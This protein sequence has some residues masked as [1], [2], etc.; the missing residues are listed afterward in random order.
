MDKKCPQ[1]K[2]SGKVPG[3]QGKKITCPV[4]KGSGK[5]PK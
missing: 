2:G 3:M 5:D 1:C 4:C